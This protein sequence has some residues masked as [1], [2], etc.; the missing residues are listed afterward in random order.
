MKTIFSL[1]I[2]ATLTLAS[3]KKD[4]TC[5]CTTTVTEPSFTYM[6]VTYQGETNTGSSTRTIKDKE[7]D[8][9]S[10][11]EKGNASTSTPSAYASWGQGPT[12]TKVDC[13]IK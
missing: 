4:Y 5:E 3:C 8:A 12:T 13:T 6:G 11:C 9:K 10:S 1:A 2:L 7:K